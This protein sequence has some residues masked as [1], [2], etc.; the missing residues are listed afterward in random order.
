MNDE[1]YKR[2]Q[3]RSKF[4]KALRDFYDKSEFIEIETPVL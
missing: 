2:F 4:V 1:S 3:L